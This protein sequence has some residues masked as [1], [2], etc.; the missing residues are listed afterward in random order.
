MDRKCVKMHRNTNLNERV[1][2]QVFIALLDR[3]LG[4]KC[5]EPVSKHVAY[6]VNA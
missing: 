5:I 3:I 1:E 6:V 2:I 4:Q